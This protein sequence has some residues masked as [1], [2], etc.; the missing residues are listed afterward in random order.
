[1]VVPLP[2]TK[3]I[4]PKI[5][6]MVCE[7]SSLCSAAQSS[8]KRKRE[9]NSLQAAAVAAANTTHSESSSHSHTTQYRPADDTNLTGRKKSNI[10]DFYPFIK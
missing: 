10:S 9:N 8:V 2:D 5:F 3:N 7:L 1:M 6:L 4:F